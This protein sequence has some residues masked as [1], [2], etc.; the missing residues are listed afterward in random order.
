MILQ[1]MTAQGMNVASHFQNLH[2]QSSLLTI[3]NLTLL[4]NDMQLYGQWKDS[5]LT[6][7]G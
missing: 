7:V 3:L 2:H 4:Q 6:Y 5:R 1:R